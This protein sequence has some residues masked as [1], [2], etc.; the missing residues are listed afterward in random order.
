MNNN[1]NGSTRFDGQNSKRAHG[2][3]PLGTSVLPEDFS[4]RLERLKKASGL[5]WRGLAKA[6]GVDPKQQDKWRGRNVEPCG[7]A[8]LSICRFAAR[9]PGGLEIIL[10]EGIQITLFEEEN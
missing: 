8:M 6:L 2:M 1:S 3:Q 4:N 9:V 5:S 10:G 7:G